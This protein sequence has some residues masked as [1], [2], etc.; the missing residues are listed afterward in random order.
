MSSCTGTLKDGNGDLK[1]YYDNGSL[2]SISNYKE[3]YL[4]GEYKEFHLNGKNSVVGSYKNNLKIGYWY[5]YNKRGLEI[6][7]EKYD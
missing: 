1:D 4:N 7:K 6:K 5:T 3:G 2:F